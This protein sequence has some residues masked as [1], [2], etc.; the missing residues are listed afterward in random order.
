MPEQ[1]ARSDTQRVHGSRACINPAPASIFQKTLPIKSWVMHKNLPDAPFVLVED[2]QNIQKGGFLFQN[3]HLLITANKIAEVQDAFS[4]IEAALNEGHYVAGYMTYELGLALEPRL[5]PKLKEPV[6][7]MWFGV[8]KNRQSFTNEEINNFLS[9]Y[10]EK[11]LLNNIKINKNL[12][13]NP[14]LSFIKYKNIFDQVKE[15]IKNG[16]IYQLNLTFKADVKGIDDPISLYA[17][18][19]RSQPVSYGGLIMTGEKTILSAS[20]ELFVERKE[21]WV[22][23]RPMKGTLRCGPTVKHQDIERDSL[24][25]DEKS[26]AENLMIVDLM[27]NDIGRIAKLGTVSVEHLFK[28]ETY[29]SLH[30]MVSIIKA[31]RLKGLCFYDEMKA[32]FPPGS[33]TGAPKI[34]SMEL[35]HDFE[36]KPRGI[37][38]GSIGF[39]TPERESV[40]NVA[41]RT[42]EVFENGQGEIG[43]GSGL[44]HDSEVK[45]EYDE[46]LLKM[47]FLEKDIPE[48]KLIETIAFSP[49]KGLLLLNEHMERLEG[50]AQYFGFIFNEEDVLTAL[51]N[52]I[53]GVK[54]PLRLRLLLSQNGKVCVTSEK[55][56]EPKE[57][58]VWHVAFADEP[59]N[60]ENV[61]LY[62]KT[63]HR[64]FYDDARAKKQREVSEHHLDEVIFVN[65]LGEVTEG[66][67]T[68]IFIETGNGK[69]LT[70]PV[71]AGLL[72]GALRQSLLKTG[73]AVEQALT[74]EDIEKAGTIYVGNSVRGLIPAK[75]VNF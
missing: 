1:M 54:F 7:L 45:A 14:R 21:G 75:L 69:L 18:M 41:I 2:S 5:A 6:P 51:E 4:A 33:I 26:R 61:F 56:D 20:P 24:R 42:V 28:I 71:D 55:M 43:I 74:R 23:T 13:I 34:R 37:Y 22:E 68:N 72:P 10:E 12:S 50:S 30:Q 47:K 44:V 39:M 35:I 66:S 19:R 8:F 60:R 29:R 16:E 73:Q 32:L 63:T 46:C 36:G 57:N 40:F 3:P 38:T 62:H 31:K 64:D 65:E 17:R 70:P 11:A 49:E 59:M 25:N 15:N 58:K 52:I 27:R 48:F 67:L 53:S 9:E